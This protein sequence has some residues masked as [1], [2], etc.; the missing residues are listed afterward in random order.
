M[1]STSFRNT[2]FWNHTT[3]MINVKGTDS[4]FFRISRE[5]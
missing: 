5:L 2:T 3:L 4:Y 1:A